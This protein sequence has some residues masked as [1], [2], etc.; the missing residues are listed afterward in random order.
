MSKRILVLFCLLIAVLLITGLAQAQQPKKVH[1]IG[2]L[3][4]PSRSS[5]SES[6]EAFR[7]GFESLVMWKVRISSSS[8]DMRA[9][10]LAVFR[11][12]RKSLVPA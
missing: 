11:P 7:E 8:T 12:W 6:V 10:S 2:F 3:L 5:A 1:R 9:E 4:A